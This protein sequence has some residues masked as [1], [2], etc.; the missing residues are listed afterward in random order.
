MAVILHF[1]TTED[2]PFLGYT[3]EGI[4]CRNYLEPHDGTVVLRQWQYLPQNNHYY[5]TKTNNNPD[6]IRERDEGYVFTKP[7]EGLIPIYHWWHPGTGDNFYT[8]DKSGEL[9]P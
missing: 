4:T 2:K 3:F 7:R 6:W 9:A 8:A 1:Y 5:T